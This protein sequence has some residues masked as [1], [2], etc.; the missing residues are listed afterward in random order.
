[1]GIKN[2]SQFLK[3]YEVQ[4]T[5]NISTLKYTKIGIDTPMFL[6]KFKGV[7][8]PNSNEWLGCFI[9]LVAFLRKWHIHPI[10]V[11]EGKAPL[12]KAQAQEE[13]R[14]QRQK[15]VDKTDS[16]QHDLDTYIGSGL[17]TPLLSEVWSKI[18]S[19]TNKS[20]LTSKKTI[21][22]NFINV[23]EIKDEINRR[24]KYEISITPEDIVMVKELLDLMGVSYIQSNDE[25]ETDCVSLFYGGLVDYIVSE[26]TDVLA[27]FEPSGNKP[28]LKVITSFNTTDLTFNQISKQKVLETLNLTSESFR[29]FCIMCGTDYNKNIFRVGVEKSYKFIKEHYIIENVPLDVDILN[30]LVVRKLFEVKEN[31]K[32]KE[33]VQWCRL[34]SS[35]FEDELAMFVF[36]NNLKNIN[37]SNVFNDLVESDI[38]VVE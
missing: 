1:M 12:E 32:I 20:L 13:R 16:I 8:D 10:F 35:T 34:P 36:T 5:L 25:A 17:V 24:R 7:Y 19:K 11:F 2:L 21:I 4:E 30:H 15:I 27:Y 23:E 9:T 18:T 38:E 33:K 37:V 26:D 14:E 31:L 28:H 29:D 3:K 22:K 6:Y